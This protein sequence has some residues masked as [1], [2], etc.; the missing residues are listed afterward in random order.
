MPKFRQTSIVR[1]ILTILI[2]ICCIRQFINGAFENVF[3]CIL[4]LLLFC[5]PNIISRR[6][7]VQL[8]AF[9]QVVIMIFIF[10]AEIL[11]EVNAYYIKIPMWD[12]MLHTLNG[13]L[14]AAIGFSLVDIFNR[15]ERF[16]VKLSPIFVAIVAFCFSMTIGVLWEF[17]EFGMDMLFHTDMQKDFFVDAIHSVALNPNNNNTPI[18]VAIHELTV[19]GE[20]WMAVYGGYLDIGLIDTMKDLFVNFIGAVVF[21]VIGY[22]YVKQRGHKNSI[23]SKLI[24]TVSRNDDDTL[25]S[26]GNPLRDK[27]ESKRVHNTQKHTAEK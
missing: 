27:D 21:S 3:T 12:T 4:C 2:V 13:F 19:N 5:V 6:F 7:A 25:D 10:S 14:M 17:F 8:P 22:F 16:L 11:G 20:D 1:T 26:F 24:P 9:L 23:A 18:H 15:S